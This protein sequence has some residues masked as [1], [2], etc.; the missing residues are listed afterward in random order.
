M[1]YILIGNEKFF[2]EEKIK[3][4]SKNNYF[5]ISLKKDKD[6]L[7]QIEGFINKRLFFDSPYIVIFDIEKKEINNDLISYFNKGNF[8]LIFKTQDQVFIKKIRTLNIPY[9]VIEVG[10]LNFRNDKDFFN[11]LKK[12]FKDKNLNFS[13]EII[14]SLAKIFISNPIMLF[15]ELKKIQFVNVNQNEF[16]DIIRW[17]NESMI[18]KLLDDLIEKKYQN[19]ILRLKREL[20]LG[21]PLNNIISLIHKTLIR[22]YLLKKAKDIRQENYLGLKFY[23]KEILKKQAKKIS[24]TEI[25]NLIKI[26]SEIDRKYKK[27]LIDENQAVYLLA[28]FFKL[29]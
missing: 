19:F 16:L 24:E 2:I 9:Q 25:V 17:P 20:S 6:Y 12:Y 28:E 15:N 29:R 5:S 11:Y 4:I 13:D 7:L 26:I 3:E 10:S 8:I 14:A 23:Y 27:F 21:T 18:F 22:V 1:I